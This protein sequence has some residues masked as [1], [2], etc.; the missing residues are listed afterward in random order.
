MCPLAVQWQENLT[1]QNWIECG[2][3]QT[4]VPYSFVEEMPAQEILQKYGE[5]GIVGIQIPLLDLTADHF[6]EVL[7]KCEALG[8][9]YLVLETME[10]TRREYLLDLVE[11]VGAMLSMDELPIYIENGCRMLRPR[12]YVHGPFSDAGALLE[13]EQACNDLSGTTRFGICFSPGYANLLG[14]N[15]R[16]MVMKLQSHIKLLHV[17]ENDGFQNDKQMPYTFT[18]TRN[19]NSI[20]WSSVIGELQKAGFAGPIVFDVEGLFA[21]TPEPLQAQMLRLLATIGKEWSMHLFYEEFLNQGKQIVLFGAGKMMLNYLISWGN[22]FPPAF[23][24]DNNEAAWG[25]VREGVRIQGPQEIL[26]IPPEE[27]LVLVCN[28]HYDEIGQQ[29]KQLGIQE[30]Y[31]YYDHYFTYLP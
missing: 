19:I 7:E 3:F 15:I 23:V 2:I 11:E 22:R 25:E 9:S 8:V 1:K 18:S 12:Y 26:K 14:Q 17:N 5:G 13:I 28:M 21:M 20:E 31:N 6:V 10:V 16:G 29:L 30:F 4:E 27:R 24:V